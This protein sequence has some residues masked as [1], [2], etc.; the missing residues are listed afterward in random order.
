MHYGR[1]SVFYCT[2]S[3]GI[4]QARLADDQ[5]SGFGSGLISDEEERSAASVPIVGL[6]MARIRHGSCRGNFLSARKN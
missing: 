4:V 2:V 1:T 6:R 5:R 3:P